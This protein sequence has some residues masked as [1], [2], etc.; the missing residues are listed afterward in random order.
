M[1]R[2]VI[3]DLDGTLVQT[4]RLKATSYAQAAHELCASCNN[5]EAVVDAF[6]EVAGLSRRDVATFL[7]ER[8]SLEPFAK[9]RMDEFNVHRPWQAFV[10]LR[11]RF[12]EAM[13]SNPALIR[14]STWPHAIGLLRHVRI[15]GF[16]TG[17]ATM[18]H[19]REASRVLHELG[20]AGSFDFIATR[21]DIEHSKPHPEIYLLV[22]SELRCSPTDCLVIEDSLPG[23]K[24]ALA[25]GMRCL[26]IPTPFTRNAMLEQTILD[27][28]W[29]VE[30]PSDLMHMFTCMVEE[31]KIEDRKL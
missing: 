29:V 20:L 2:A 14:S 28:R 3:F 21:D 6:K 1:I 10:Q 24:A 13:L 15:S 5:Q 19:C 9:S 12:Y 26:C 4:E 18:S 8:F 23:V 27:Q 30:E 7:L 25:A 22:A 31:R 11:L 17:L 16:K